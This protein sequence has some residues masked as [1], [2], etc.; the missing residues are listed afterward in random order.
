MLYGRKRQDLLYPRGASATAAAAVPSAGAGDA[1]GASASG[2]GGASA[3]A[4]A[5]GDSAKRQR[6]LFAFYP[7][8]QRIGYSKEA[9][10]KGPAE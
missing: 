9:K 8:G 5:A 2:A 3:N 6:T 1:G 10:G 4:V 7:K